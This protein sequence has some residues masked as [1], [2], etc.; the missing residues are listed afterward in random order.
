MLL[1]CTPETGPIA[2]NLPIPVD[3]VAICQRLREA[4]YAAYVVGGAV[5]DL[6]LRTLDESAANAKDFDIATA[7]PPEEVV[8]LFGPRRTIPTGIAHG[9]VTVLC[10]HKETERPRHVEVTTFRGESGYSDGR[11][12]DRVEFIADLVEDLRR[13]DFTINAIAYDPL[14]GTLHD[15][16]LGRD[17]LA[18]KRVRAVGDPAQ[19]FAEDGLRLLRA[20]R[21]A[22]QLGFAIDAETRAAFLP[23]LQTLRKV[24]RERIRD[25][26]LRLLAAKEPS[27]G[28]IHMMES[29]PE[30]GLDTARGLLGVV[31]PE[32]AAALSQMPDRAA[33]ERYISLVDTL[34]KDQRLLALLWPLRSALAGIPPKEQS[35]RLDE[36]LKLS[37]QDRQHLLAVL[38]LEEPDYQPGNPWPGPLL[39]RFLARHPQSVVDDFLLVQRAALLLCDTE[40][41]R[42]KRQALCA[43]ADRI[44]AE[45]VEQPP[46]TAAELAISGKDLMARLALRPGPLV[47]EALRHLL[48]FVLDEPQRNTPERLLAEAARYLAQRNAAVTPQ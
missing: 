26:I 14:H 11:R 32:V 19:R 43:L 42:V 8:R 31:L 15:P 4:G 44:V 12:P 10:S 7:A 41:A 29:T 22:A 23:A 6:L 30:G 27:R 35:D 24:S 36:L 25:E 33:A 45:R 39:R 18:R 3:V 40:A 46:L 2:A 1:A 34:P 17:D 16:F 20:V 21:F 5:R 48:E 13:R 47:G 37:N 28:L 38:N 9:T